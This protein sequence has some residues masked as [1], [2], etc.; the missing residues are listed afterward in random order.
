MPGIKAVGTK[1]A[2]NQGDADDRAREFLHGFSRGVFGSKTLFDVALH[3]FDD[4]DGI[5]DHQADGQH[6]PEHRKGIDGE[7][8]EREKNKGAH[9]RD[10]YGQQRDQ[11]GAP[12][13]QEEVDNQD[14]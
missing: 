13:L 4:D 10:G 11:R 1:T 2:D 12:V 7:A 6:Q 5:V 14:D 3:A 8:K 9:Q